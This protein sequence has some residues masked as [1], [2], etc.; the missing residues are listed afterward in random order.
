MTTISSSMTSTV[1]VV[2]TG[3]ERMLLG[4]GRRLEGFA[5]ARMSRRTR[6]AASS[7]AQAF[8]EAADRRRTAEAHGAFGILPR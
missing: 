5:L 2:P 7:A 3:A 1:R 8:S 6:V 4:L